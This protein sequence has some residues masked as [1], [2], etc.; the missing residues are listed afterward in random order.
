[1]RVKDKSDKG[2][3]F[4]FISGQLNA[5]GTYDV[6]TEKL[7]AVSLRQQLEKVGYVRRDTIKKWTLQL[8]DYLAFVN[9][10]DPK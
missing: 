2:N 9:K 3:I 8:L 6:I 7:S 10:Q 4:D 5:D 1:M